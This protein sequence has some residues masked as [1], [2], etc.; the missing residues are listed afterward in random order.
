MAQGIQPYPGHPVPRPS[1]GFGCILAAVGCAL[2]V[3]LLAV[4]AA[5]IGFLLTERMPVAAPPVLYES[6]DK[7]R[8]SEESVQI[9]DRQYGPLTIECRA[10]VKN[11]TGQQQDPL[12]IFQFLDEDGLEIH[13]RRFIPE[14]RLP[15]GGDEL[16]IRH[17]TMNPEDFE[18]VK[19][20][21]I[22]E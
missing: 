12:L 22:T 3:G 17:T 4:V 5:A 18:R 14:F 11:L 13:R 19:T 10:R 21:R 16:M 2:A 9:I 6:R 8:V 15:V 1:P 7:I 20:F